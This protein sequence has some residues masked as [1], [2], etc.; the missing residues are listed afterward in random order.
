MYNFMH[1]SLE[2][3][4]LYFRNL[5][6]SWLLTIVMLPLDIVLGEDFIILQNKQERDR[7]FILSKGFVD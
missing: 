1:L 5:I 3:T 4:D 7:R 2:N 6:S